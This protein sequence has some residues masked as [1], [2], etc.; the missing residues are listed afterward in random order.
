MRNK[1]L[2]IPLIA[3]VFF[4][5]VLPNSFLTF[6]KNQIPV[7][8]GKIFIDKDTILDHDI[9][10][11]VEI[12]ADNIT[13]DC[14]G[15]KITSSSSHCES[16]FHCDDYGIYLVGK[17]GVTIK[18]CIVIDFSHGI[19]IRHSINNTLTNNIV[20]NSVYGIDINYS[21]NNI[22]TGNAMVDNVY[23]FYLRGCLGY[24]NTID[25][26]NTVDGKP[27]YY[28]ENAR[29]QVYDSSTNA[30]TFY[31]IRCD[32]V[33][34]KDLTLTQNGFGILFRDTKN[35]RIE[36]V[37]VSN[38]ESGI[39]FSFSSNNTLVDSTILNNNF[40]VFLTD[41]CENNK[42]YHNNFINNLSQ[43]E[44][45]YN[46]NNLFD[47]G[48]PEGGNYWSNYNGIDEKSGPNQDQPGSDGIGD[49]PYT[50]LATKDRY[51]F[52]KKIEKVL[53]P[54][55]LNQEALNKL[56]SLEIRN[57]QLKSF[58]NKAISSIEQSLEDRYW[59]NE[60]TAKYDMKTGKWMI[61][62]EI[63]A[64]RFLDIALKKGVTQTEREVIE[65]SLKDLLEADQIL[66]NDS[67][68]KARNLTEA[69]TNLKAA[70]E[71]LKN[72]EYQRAVFKFA[73]S[74]ESSQKAIEL[75]EE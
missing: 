66:A 12:T 59:F 55:A 75:E 11:S 13:L 14:N 61:S 29:N 33:T 9:T 2:K 56:K 41:S 23:N 48:Y 1:L 47:N 35:S 69:E 40:G 38:N 46:S 22:L 60:E 57:P 16:S 21:G 44:A 37:T 54:K 18:N 36:N 42:I 15:H 51:P 10:G 8:E 24:Y 19:Y 4:G 65:E 63:M 52:M 72:K 30:G 3:L 27:I 74:W 7:E 68:N 20:L 45:P 50:Y 53:T 34:L 43:S 6:A 67:L 73:L 25:T 62:R 17:D 58:I 64:V 49:T 31:C 5:L 28:I 70:K 71:Y 26:S 32:N 39:V